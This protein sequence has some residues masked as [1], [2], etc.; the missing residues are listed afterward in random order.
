M[1]EAGASNRTIAED[2]LC[3]RIELANERLAMANER[4]AM[5]KGREAISVERTELT[6]RW[7]VDV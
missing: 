3:C 5:A 7:A 6:E 4:V 2:L 1:I